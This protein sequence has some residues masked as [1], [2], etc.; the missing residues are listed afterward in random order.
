M[1]SSQCA[2]KDVPVS[3]G[4]DV[5]KA[6]LEVA[7]FPE[8]LTLS[9]DNSAAGFRELM[10]ALKKYQVERV[11]MEATGAYERKV[12]AELLSAGYTV[13]IANPRQVRDFARGL[14]ILAKTDKIDAAVIAK[15][16]DVVKPKPR[17]RP[18]VEHEELRA[19]VARR[20]QLADLKVQEKCHL[21][22]AAE[23]HAR[24][25]IEKVLKVLNAQI[26]HLDTLICESIEADD[27]LR[28][29]N[30][31]I[32]SP[33][34]IGLQTSSMLLARLPELGT[35]N[36]QKIASLAG[37]AP[38]DVQSGPWKGKKRIWG[39]RSDVRRALYMA[40]V[41]ARNDN[42]V[43]REFAQ[44]L[45]NAGKPFNVVIVACMRKLLVIL[46]TMIRNDTKWQS[47][48]LQNCR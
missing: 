38:W 28:H 23:K 2:P 14:G 16:A 47:R 5:A 22:A 32:D 36:R 39:G 20:R 34:G 42:P 35:L 45:E 11:V 1:S 12:A 43:I 31:I 26:G 19:L 8:G 4:I 41:S 6:T 21:E 17:P 30:E 40:A 44:R 48:P 7:S 13:V 9:P 27:E 29:K 25:S 3:V 15:F 18:S 10:S 37:V 33:K 24:R 46:N